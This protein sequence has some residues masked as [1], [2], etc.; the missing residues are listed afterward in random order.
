[1]MAK[2]T[3]DEERALKRLQQKREAPESNV[4]KSLNVTVDL[5][6]EKQVERAQRLGLL[7]S[8]PDDSDGDSDDGDEETPKRKGY[9][10]GD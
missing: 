1:M 4:A 6:D 8:F 3:A 7:D 5:A 9:F 2:L 10:D